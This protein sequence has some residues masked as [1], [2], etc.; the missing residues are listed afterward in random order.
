MDKTFIIIIL[1]FSLLSSI[2]FCDGIIIH[3]RYPYHLIDENYQ[4]AAINHQDGMQKMII[5]INIDMK[6]YSEALWIFPIPAEPNKVAIDILSEFPKF[7]GNEIEDEVRYTLNKLTKISQLTH[8]YPPIFW[9]FFGYVWGGGITASIDRL[10]DISET[11]GPGVIIHE[12][13]EKEGIT[14]ELITAKSGEALYGYL[15]ARGLEP[16]Q[17]VI[18]ILDYYIG[19]DYS[20]VVSWISSSNYTYEEEYPPAYEE[21]YPP[22][23]PYG[24]GYKRMYYKQVGVFISFPTDKIYYPLFPT[25]VYGSKSIPIRLYVIDYVTP[26][27]YNEIKPYTEIDYYFSRYYYPTTLELEKFYSKHEN[28]RYTIIEINAPAKYLTQD[29]WISKKAPMK[30]VY[31]DFLNSLLSSHPS[32]SLFVIIAI[33]SMIA[34]A[35]TGFILF[36]EVKK[37]ALVGLANIFSIIGLAIAMIFV[38]TKG[39]DKKVEEEIKS[40]GLILISKKK[41]LFVILFSILFIII[42]LIIEK[43]IL[44]P[45]LL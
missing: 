22:G 12:H 43:L 44:L 11:L 5:G 38:K 32:I 17:T 4:L 14:T 20:F 33:Y 37:Y 23:P 3:P 26:E 36:R 31:A 30:V 15:R 8:I 29:L 7:Y 2:G 19:K 34:G 28:I 45:L 24:I 41:I 40:A 9:L 39:I 25:S 16:R 35:I 6:N 27:I 42:S 13:I 10:G 21:E 1:F 18:P